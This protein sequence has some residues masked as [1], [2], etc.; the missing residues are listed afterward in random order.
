MG[1]RRITIDRLESMIEYLNKITGNIN[2]YSL[3][4]NGCGVRLEAHDGSVGIL[5]RTSKREQCALIQAYT[6]GVGVQKVTAAEA[7]RRSQ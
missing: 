4:S 1:E 7:L 6:A 2:D 3:A 5:P